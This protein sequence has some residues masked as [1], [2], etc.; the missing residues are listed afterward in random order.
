M[1]LI[2]NKGN[3]NQT[4]PVITE[5]KSEIV[6]LINQ[7]SQ[8]NIES[9]IR[10][11][12]QFFRVATSPSALTVQNW[13]VD[14]FESYGYDDVSIHYFNMGSQQLAAGNVVVIKR[15]TEFPDEYIMITSHYDHSTFDSPV[16]PGADDNASGTAGVMECARLLANFDTKRSI[17][18]VPFN[19]EEYW[20]VGSL[21]FAKKCATEN[22]NIIAHFNMDMIGWFPPGN[23]NTIMA[24]GYSYISKTLFEYYHQ[25]ANTYIPSIPTIRLSDGDSYGGDHMPFNMYEYPSLY[26]GDIEYHQ[27]HPCYHKSCDTIGPH[28]APN[29]G[30]N[31]LDLAKAFVQ[32][33]LSAAAELAN[34][35]L[36]PQ[37][38]SACSGID[39]ITVSWDSSG[40]ND[41]YKI[42]KN[43]TLIDIT[44]QTYYVD[45]EVIRGQKYEYYVVALSCELR[46]DGDPSNKEE[47]TFVEPMP[48]PYFNDFS[49]N[50][51]GFEQ[52][53]WVLRNASGK[54]SI[55]NTSG[56]GS[57]PDNYLSIAESDW[58]AIPES[59]EDISVRFKWRG[60]LQGIWYNTGLFF[61]VTTDR[62]T[63]HKLAYISG[64]VNAWQE[65][66]FPLNQYINSEFFQIRFRLESSGAQNA[67]TK[68]GYV[69][70]VEIL[71]E[72]DTTSI[73]ETIPYI[74]SFNI[75]PNPAN[76]SITVVTEQQEPYHIA[77]YDMNGRVMFTQNGFRDGILSVANLRSGNYIIVASYHQHRFA[78]KL[79]IQ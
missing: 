52:S 54:S 32:A 23:S 61:E 11:M 77:I 63:W 25:T 6:N 66:S 44:T 58:F 7:V 15:G 13:L 34:A 56:G 50:K 28:G 19:A 30:V 16:G 4:Y 76:S 60:N 51:N 37:N 47:I 38:L 73:K 72:S 18:F 57:F 36:P 78:R 43:N 53:N 31:R 62:K 24:S 12:Q 22:M 42:Y 67:Y 65:R 79:V 68:I 48:L 8:N 71:F 46:E 3:R 64:N 17:M 29:C 41:L 9:Y 2:N 40:E 69:T 27:Q 14:K 45:Y 33:T 1:T 21:P 49:V 55:C 10:Y 75:F 39:K 5:T 35:W 26:I 74:T 59:T 20:M 70:D